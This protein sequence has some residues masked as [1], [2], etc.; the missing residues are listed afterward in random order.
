MASSEHTNREREILMMGTRVRCFTPLPAVSLEE[1]VPADHFY[2]FLD[3]ALDL[4][5]VRPLVQD[6]YAGSGRPSVDP[7]VFFRLQLVM[8]FEGICSERLLMRTVADRLSVRWY[9]GYNLDEPLPDHSS[10]TRIRTRYGLEVFRCF[11]EAIV[12]QCQQA[13]LVRGRELYFDATHVLADAALDSLTARFAVKAREALQAHLGALFPDET[14]QE[15]HGE[16][17][18]EAP[19]EVADVAPQAAAKAL[20][21]T[22]E[23]NLPGPSV[24]LPPRSLPVDLPDLLREELAAANAARHDWIAQD[25]RQQREV[26]GVYQRTADFRISTTD[27]DATPLRLKGGG[28]HLGYQTH[29]V[30]DG[31]KRRIILG[32]LVAPGEVM[33]NQPMLDLLWHVR[34]RWKLQPR[35]VTGDTTYGTLE[36]IRAVEDMGIR[37]YVPLPDWEQNSPYFGASKFRYE[38]AHDH[39]VCPHGQVLRRI[40]TFA[41]GQRVQYRAQAATC[42]TCPL[43]AQCTPGTK[44]GRSVWRAFGEEYLERVQAYQSTAAYQKAV[45]KRQVWVE[46]LFAEGKQWHGMRRFHGRR[47][48][49]VNSEALLLASGQNLKRLLQRRGW[50]R[51]P[52]PTGAVA[53]IDPAEKVPLCLWLVVK[54]V[55]TGGVSS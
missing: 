4:S 17:L 33:E 1:L 36:N 23:Q 40:Y 26:H 51:R 37:A 27:P 45:R 53:A 15:A 2:R 31:G 52:F 46:P 11:F 44:V 34:F 9:L 43:K 55:S 8:F 50:G 7:V 24:P 32:V 5:F 42:R 47:L 41:A 12:A 20:A 38:A 3:R 25:G 19:D 29:Y 21:P 22:Q 10:L 49:R 35:Q 14:I 18:H 48:W 13:G 30:V 16:D 39:Y 6:Y 54:L 28:T